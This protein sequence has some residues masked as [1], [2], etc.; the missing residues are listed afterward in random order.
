MLFY[1]RISGN[2][3]LQKQP[4]VSHAN[5]FH[6]SR[7][8]TLKAFTENLYRNRKQTFLTGNIP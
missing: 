7:G 8:H 6:G 2:D 5:D 4:H 1:V 3:Q